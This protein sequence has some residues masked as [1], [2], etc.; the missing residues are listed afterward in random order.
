MT[1][2]LKKGSGGQ[3][4]FPFD[5]VFPAAFPLAHLVFIGPFESDSKMPVIMGDVSGELE[6]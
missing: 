1:L 3:T 5:N 4:V 6:R 2:H